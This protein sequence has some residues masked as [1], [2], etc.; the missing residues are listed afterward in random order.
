[1]TI[2]GT[3]AEA[4]SEVMLFSLACRSF[5]SVFPENHH[6]PYLPHRQRLSANLFLRLA[7]PAAAPAAAA[8]AA[9]IVTITR[10]MTTST[11]TTLCGLCLHVASP[12]EILCSMEQS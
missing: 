2:E 6:S 7:A 8:A 10:T 5:L 11:A 4:G 9:R 3:L 12:A 1:M